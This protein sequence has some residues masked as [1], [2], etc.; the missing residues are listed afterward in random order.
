MVFVRARSL[1]SGS[2]RST[3]RQRSD[4]VASAAGFVIDTEGRVLTNAHAVS[5]AT[6]IRVTFSDE[7]T[8]TAQVLGK[9]EET[10]LALLGVEPKGLDLRPLRARQLPLGAGRRPD[11]LDRQPL[12]PATGP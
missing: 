3:S 7:K 5:G 10:D 8:V 1:Q 9:D 4:G 12:R 11:G 2:S 6:D